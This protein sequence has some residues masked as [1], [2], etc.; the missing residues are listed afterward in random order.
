MSEDQNKIRRDVEVRLNEYIAEQQAAAEKIDAGYGQQWE[1]IQA[2][3]S[4]GG[5]RLRPLLLVTAYQAFG[6]EDYEA[7]LSLAAAQEMLHAALLVHDDIIDRQTVRRG[8][9]NVAGRY[10]DIYKDDHLAMGAALLAGDL[11][12]SAAYQLLNSAGLQGSVG[13]EVSQLFGRSIHEVAGGQLID[14]ESAVRQ[15]TTEDALR[16][17]QFKTASYS[18]EGPLVIGAVA[19]G[20]SEQT[21]ATL[22]QFARHVGIAFQLVDD[23]L[24]MFGEDADIGKSSLADLR[25]G[26]Q[27]VL[28]TLARELMPDDDKA[29]LEATLGN[30]EA[31]RDELVRVREM[32]EQR[33]VRDR[34][35]EL[36]AEHADKARI[37]LDNLSVSGMGK[38]RL[39]ELLEAS[40]RRTF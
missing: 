8:Q 3:I 14:M 35:E 19:A 27:T 34:A 7:A 38:R 31:G 20:A 37:I 22:R 21:V 12:I 24:G 2:F 6:G 40:T 32:L 15:Y 11:C 28:V 10:Q 18:F 30:A 23:L 13:A 26:K 16:V 5:K 36:V 17:A 33:G 25:E 29:Y 1:I 4:S 39:G 9:P